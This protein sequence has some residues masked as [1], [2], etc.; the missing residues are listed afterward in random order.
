VIAQAA[1]IRRAG[2][3]AVLTRS[4]AVRPRFVLPAGEYV[5]R[6]RVEGTWRELPLSLTPGMQLEMPIPLP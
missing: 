5:A 4:D 2:E 3:H 1:E 6:V